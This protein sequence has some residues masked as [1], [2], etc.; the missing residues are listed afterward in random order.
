MGGPKIEKLG[1][2]NY[3]T[4]STYFKAFLQSEKLW[5][6]VQHREPPEGT[7]AAEARKWP[8]GREQAWSQVIMHVQPLHLPALATMNGDP[9][10]A[11]AYFKNRHSSSSVARQ[12]QLNQQ[13]SHF[14]M[15]PGE[16]IVQYVAR[17]R[18]L[19]QQLASTG[20]EISAHSL[21]IYILS[22]LPSDFE[23]V[24]TSIMSTA[25]ITGTQLTSIS[26]IEQQLLAEI[27]MEPHGSSN[28]EHIAAAHA[29]RGGNRGGRTAGRAQRVFNPVGQRAGPS[30]NSNRGRPQMS[31]RGGRGG[32]GSAR[33]GAVPG[34]DGRLLRDIDCYN[35]HRYG[36]YAEQCPSPAKAN[37]ALGLN[38]A[39]AYSSSTQAHAPTQ[40]PL[41]PQLC[42]QHFC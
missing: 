32:R 25:S 10:A 3:L 16:R 4:W 28:R 35:C 5:Q 13:L 37:A 19:K 9:Q 29:M 22:G 20:Q 23:V 18:E 2:D 26:N 40:R 12:V 36:H 21:N 30:T 41:C 42:T 31:N 7:P 38:M 15:Q 8:E 11:W 27:N 34:T 33:S 17:A 14:K 1:V 24:K 39:H 6:Y